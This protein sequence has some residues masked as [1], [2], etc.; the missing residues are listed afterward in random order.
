MRH[1]SH[2]RAHARTALFPPAA[3]AGLLAAAALLATASSAPA[4][5]LPDLTV[6]DV[7][8]K[9]DCRV[10]ATVK[11]LG[12][13]PLPTGIARD[14]LGV[15]Y[16][17]D[18]GAFGG[19]AL[20][21]ED[22]EV[23]RPAGGT[24]VT[25]I[26][27]ML[28]GEG[29][30]GAMADSGHYVKEAN[31]NNNTFTKRLSCSMS[32]PAI[33]ITGI[34]I[35]PPGCA[36]VLTLVNRG[37]GVVPYRTWDEDRLSRL[38]DGAHLDDEDGPRLQD[39][40]P[41][42]LLRPAGGS[43]EWTDPTE[44]RAATSVRYEFSNLPDDKNEMT[45]P[46]TCL[47]DLVIDGMTTNERCDILVALRNAGPGPMPSKPAGADNHP[48]IPAATLQFYTSNGKVF[49][50]AGGWR[51]GSAMMLALRLPGGTATYNRTNPAF[52]DQDPKP[53][54]ALYRVDIV[55]FGGFQETRADNNRLER[56]INCGP[57]PVVAA[58][59]F[60]RRDVVQRPTPLAEKRPVAVKAAPLAIRGV[61]W[62]P[63]CRAVLTLANTSGAPL[64][65][66]LY[67]PTGVRLE[68]S[69]SGAVQATTLLGKIDPLQ[70]LRPAGAVLEWV[71]PVVASVGPV[72]WELKG[73]GF[74]LPIPSQRT[75]NIPTRCGARLVVPRR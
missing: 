48:E 26:G 61:A 43:V 47:P 54:H 27:P 11:N 30:I 19:W 49:Q 66:A 35:S 23:L 18:G 31:E 52:P 42:H 60:G 70:K 56:I 9:A 10:V 53:V 74:G 62:R 37:N 17:K 57:G 28:N 12:P 8:T 71:D 3:C 1:P 68:R 63:D 75:E 45:V 7:T 38:F 22:I 51:M 55:N 25:T 4:Q 72:R 40:D 29:D 20:S 2:R 44:F 5:G 24:L 46:S 73:P 36:P 39:V 59:R 15:Q 64:D 14:T 32:L 65:R 50:N 69:V 34:R 21:P 13:G 58:P 41:K 16:F 33:T 6:T 67:P